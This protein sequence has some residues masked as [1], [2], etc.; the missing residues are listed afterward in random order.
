MAT[1]LSIDE[2]EDPRYEEAPVPAVLEL[3]L[4]RDGALPMEPS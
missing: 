4:H 2:P 1:A 3:G